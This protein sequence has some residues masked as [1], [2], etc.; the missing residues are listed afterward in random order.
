MMLK[1]KKKIFGTFKV[2][3]HAPHHEPAKASFLFF[4]FIVFLLYSRAILSFSLSP[5]LLLCPFH[6]FNCCV[7]VEKLSC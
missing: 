2:Q 6:C 7:I 4:F 1:N 5:S 3:T